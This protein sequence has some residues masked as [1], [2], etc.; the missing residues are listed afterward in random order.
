MSLNVLPADNPADVPFELKLYTPQTPCSAS[1][2]SNGGVAGRP[3]ISP[4]VSGMTDVNASSEL[5]GSH[6]LK[7]S[8]CPSPAHMQSTPTLKVFKTEESQKPI[9]GFPWSHTIFR[10]QSR[11]WRIRK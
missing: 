10:L 5:S 9:S 6:I 2:K 1:S 7:G 8:D 3:R 11:S 4:V